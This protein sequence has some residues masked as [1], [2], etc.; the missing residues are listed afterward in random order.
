MGG[1]P[2]VMGDYQSSYP[3]HGVKLMI[4]KNK[5]IEVGEGFTHRSGTCVQ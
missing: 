3:V 1:G 4:F 2:S 5:T